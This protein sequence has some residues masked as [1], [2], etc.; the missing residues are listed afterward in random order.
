M[1]TKPRFLISRLGA[2]GDVILTTPIIRKIHQDRGGF[3]EI[4][5][6]TFAVD[7]FARNPHVHQILDGRTPIRPEDF[8]CVINLDLAYEKN[9][10][11]HILD[12]YGFYA[13]GGQLDFDRTCELFPGDEDQRFGRAIAESLPGGFIVMHMRRVPQSNK[14]PPESFWQEVVLGLLAETPWSILQIG[15]AGE[16]AFGGDPRLVDLRG[17]LSIH[18]LREVI[19]GARSFSAMDSG[20]SWV[21]STTT[22]NTVVFYTT[23]R[24]EYRL[25]SRHGGN[26]TVMTPDIPCYGCRERMP[27]GS[28]MV[29]CER[30][31]EDCVN[32][33]DPRAA[34]DAIKAASA[35]GTSAIT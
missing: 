17:Q 29:A 33:F 10:K 23:A 30:G 28:T 4:S 20:P 1:Q 11:V 13:F 3:C 27:L 31:D 34:I 5:V 22:T 24:A 7:V 8:D 19:A 15:A 12:A 14:S 6:R 26:H 32:R 2:L 25:P 21:A 9:P 35:P 16:I 18:Q